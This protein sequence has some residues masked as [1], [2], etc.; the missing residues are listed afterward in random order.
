MM[1]DVA[2]FRALT[3]QPIDQGG[4]IACT[5]EAKQCPDGSFVGRVTPD[6]EFAPCPQPV[7]GLQIGNLHVPWWGLA[8]GLAA[9]WYFFLRGKS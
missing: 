4:L 1:M 6:C 9:L 7:G 3:G 5:Q 8:L 2:A